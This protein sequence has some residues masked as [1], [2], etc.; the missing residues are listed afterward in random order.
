MSYKNIAAKA[1]ENHMKQEK[2]QPG[3]L[4]MLAGYYKPYKGLFFADLFFAFLGAAVTLVIPLM[5]R[6]IMNSISEMPA[7]EAKDHD[8]EKSGWEC[9]Y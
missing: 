3:R 7:A 8:F 9:W 2:K 1:E 4:K 6:Y 5:V